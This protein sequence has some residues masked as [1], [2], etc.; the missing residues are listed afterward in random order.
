[1]EQ[2]PHGPNFF[3]DAFHY[4]FGRTRTSVNEP[5]HPASESALQY[6]H[7]IQSVRLPPLKRR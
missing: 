1:M 2:H 4:V 5:E 3:V 6:S 7:P